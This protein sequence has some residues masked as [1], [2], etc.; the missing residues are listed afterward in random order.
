[1]TASPDAPNDQQFIDS[2]RSALVSTSAGDAIGNRSAPDTLLESIVQAAARAIPCPEGALFLIDPE[3]RV[4]TFDIVIG[5]TAGNVRDLTVPLG[6]GIAGLVASSGQALAVA[7]AQEDP[8][9]ARDIAEKSGYLPTT[10]LAVPVIGRDSSPIGVLELLDRQDQPTFS[11]ADM[12]LLGIFADQVA[13]VLEMRR[14]HDLLGARI[15]A[16][17]ATLAGLPE[18]SRTAL[19]RHTQAYVDRVQADDTAQQTET[20]ATLVASI[21]S[22]GPAEHAMCVEVLTA[23][24]NYLESSPSLNLGMFR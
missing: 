24:A 17:I 12:E 3:R 10:I 7:N 6:H 21:A 2:L 9:H 4:L 23:I 19:M 22:R 14:S 1:M 11:L 18:E 5:S 16:V 13:T 15:G 8:R 20:L